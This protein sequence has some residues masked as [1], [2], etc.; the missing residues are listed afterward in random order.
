MFLCFFGFKL[1]G[2]NL[3]FQLEINVN[4]AWEH[5][6]KKIFELSFISEK[7]LA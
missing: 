7:A 4:D 6:D 1:N 5:L 2:F 3:K